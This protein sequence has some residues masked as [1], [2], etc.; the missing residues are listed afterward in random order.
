LE[1]VNRLGPGRLAAAAGVTIGLIVFFVFLATRLATSQLALLFDDLN[2]EDSARVANELESM[3]ITFEAS[4]DGRQIRVP[5]DR[6]ARLRLRLAE[7]GMPEDGSIGY[8]IFDRDQTLGTSSFVQ[9]INHV[10]ALEREL[11][12]TIATLSPVKAARVHLVLPRRELFSRRRLDPSASIVMKMRGANRLDRDQVRAIQH[13]VATAV[14]GLKVE[15]ISIIDD[16]GSLLSRGGNDNSQSAAI[17]NSEERRVAF[18]MSLDRS[19]EQLL[20]PSLGIGNVRTEINVEMDFDRVVTNEEI[21]DPEGQVARSTQ[22]I[23]ESGRN[24]ESDSGAV[25]VGQNLPNAPAGDNANTSQAQTNR[26]EEAANF[27]IS[28]TIR[29]HVREGGRINR[30]S[31][32]ILINDRVTTATDGTQTFEPRTKEELANIEKLVKSPVGFNAKRGDTIEVVNMRFAETPEMLTGFEDALFLGFSTSDIRR[33]VEVLV[34]AL[35]GILII[36]LVVRPLIAKILEP[37]PGGAARAP[38]GDQPR[39]T[40]QGGVETPAALTGPDGAIAG[41]GDIP[42]SLEEMLNVDQVE[43]L[44]KASSMNKIGDI[45]DRH[46]EEAVSII[47]S[48][49]YQDQT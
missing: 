29:Q 7:Q 4:P 46:P 23:T 1:T 20:E 39:L 18:Q 13:L 35:V 38:G 34:L 5:S 22:T 47:R 17:L 33:L 2:A 31:L 21:F 12:R 8:E 49:I 14:P 11:S 6:V 30:I 45:I 42:G 15:R 48:W 25:S 27:E 16:R 28:K 24:T 3:G 37:T 9:N 36:L 10:R 26:T 41:G 19:I 32:A 44:V 43:G 40:Q